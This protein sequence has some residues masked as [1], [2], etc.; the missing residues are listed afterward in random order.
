M[1]TV[2]IA[3]V[4]ILAVASFYFLKHKPVVAVILTGLGVVPLMLGS[5]GGSLVASTIAL[6]LLLAQPLYVVL[7]VLTLLSFE[8]M[9]T[10]PLRDFGIFPEKIFG[11]TDKNE[12]LAIPFFV[13]S[14]AIMTHGGIAKRLIDFARALTGWMPGGLAIAAIGGCVLF[15]AISGSG[16]PPG[17][18]GFT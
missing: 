17:P 12:L 18:S 11:L 5:Y 16:L 9:A 3:V 7:G 15:A 2:S 4:V 13:I 6:S 10:V 8:Y 14:G 1:E